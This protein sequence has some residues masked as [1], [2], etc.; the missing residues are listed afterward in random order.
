MSGKK[1]NKD[2][3]TKLIAEIANTHQGDINYVFK[4]LAELKKNNI[5]YVKFQIYN[6]NELLSRQHIRYK[7]FLKQSFTYKQW[8]KIINYSS[9]YFKICFDIFGEESLDYILKKKNIYGI[10]IHSSDLVNKAILLKLSNFKNKIF[11]SSGGS[12][13]KEI[14]Y[15]LSFFKKKKPVLMH[16]YQNY[17]T[18]IQD[19][20]LDRIKK[21]KEIYKKKV[22]YGLQDH[23]AGGSEESHIVPLI[24]LSHNLSFIE[25]HV[26]LKRHKKRVDYFSSLEPKEI[27]KLINKINYY[28][29]VFIIKEKFSKKETN[30]RKIVKKNWV[31]KKEINIGEVF[32]LKNIQMKRVNSKKFN[33]F[34]FEELNN[35]ICS[36]NLGKDELITKKNFKNKVTALVIVRSDSKRLKNK[37]LLKINKKTCLEILIKRLLLSKRLNNIIICT[38]KNKEDDIIVKI[39]KK[40]K[41]DFFRGSSLNVLSRMIGA[42]KKDNSQ[43]LVRVTGDDILIDPEYLDKAIDLAIK[44]NSD[45]VTNKGIPSGCEVEIFTKKCL[46]DLDRYSINPDGTEYLTN[47]ITDHPNEFS[48]SK[49]SIPKKLKKNYRLT[50]DTKEDFE[51]VKKILLHF[52]KFDFSLSDLIKYYNSHKNFFIN[53]NKIEQKK[54]PSKY[55]TNMRW[56]I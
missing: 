54:I 51:V 30:Y 13:F 27:G 55:S 24:A 9:K 18:E 44:S 46:F 31:A 3:D 8:D 5:N 32:S 2:A 52:K 38:T 26:I 25:K 39:A 40:N 49:L 56:G 6:A 21:Y 23:L 15:A 1:F 36:K 42:F 12:N 17:P 22:S 48:S 14:D 4:L 34:F 28:K 47:Y 41:V 19:T 43:L 29:K 7:H 16:G 35:K 10:K 50:I 53:H 20:C 45:Y 11:I 37:A 33:P